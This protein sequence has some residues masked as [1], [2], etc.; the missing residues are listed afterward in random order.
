[1]SWSVLALVSAGALGCSDK[2]SG[3]TGE[4]GG[5]PRTLTEVLAFTQI[6]ERRV[7]KQFLA[8]ARHPEMPAKARQTFQIMIEDEKDHLSWVRDWLQTRAD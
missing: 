8:E 7:H 5:A 4:E 3:N 1:M 6:F 2:G